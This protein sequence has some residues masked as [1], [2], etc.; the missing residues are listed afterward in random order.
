MN[1]TRS[2]PTAFAAC[3]AAARDALRAEGLPDPVELA[4]E[5]AFDLLNQSVGQTQAATAMARLGAE[6][7]DD[8]KQA[9]RRLLFDI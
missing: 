3:V 9:L 1:A 5:M 7:T 8:H 4:L 2:D 6:L